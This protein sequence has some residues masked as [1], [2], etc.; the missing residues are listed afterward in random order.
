MKWYLDVLTS[1]YLQFDGRAR[2]TEYWMYTLF[3][4]IA[5]VALA[6]VAAIS[7]STLV[8]A[9][10]LLYALATLLPSLAVSIRRL[11]DSGRSGWWLLVGIVP[12]LGGVALLYFMV[13]PGEQG[14]N[15]F[16]PDPRIPAPASM[17]TA[18]AAMG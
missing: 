12:L 14:A 18:G 11:H 6:G 15:G 9:I 17:P 3:N 13:I 2:R 1:K 10:Y 4:L 8:M 5:L 16:G 7:S